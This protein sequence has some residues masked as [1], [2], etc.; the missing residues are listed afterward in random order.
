MDRSTTFTLDERD[1]RRGARVHLLR[2]MRD[3]RTRLRLTLLWLAATLVATAFLV[4]R[5]VP[6][7]EVLGH[8]PWLALGVAAAVL[9]F[10]F[11]LP[12]VLTPLVVRQRFRREALLREPVVAQWDEA[13]YRA[14]QGGV[15]SQV[16]WRTYVACQESRDLFVFFLSDYNF[17]LVP[18]RA[19][20]AAQVDDLRTLMAA[21]WAGDVGH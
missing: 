11:G 5:D 17:Q 9:G 1:H 7:P 6:W 20:D 3:R 10:A 19:L 13:A 14:R 18:K 21:R 2:A 8:L 4:L 16:A 15:E 12:L